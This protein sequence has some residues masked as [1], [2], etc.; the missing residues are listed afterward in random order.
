MA[1]HI[2]EPAGVAPSKKGALDHDNVPRPVA[3]DFMYD[4][5]YNHDLPTADVLGVEVPTDCDAQREAENIMA[6]LSKATSKED[7]V[8]FTDLFFDHGKTSSH[9]VYEN[10]SLPDMIGVWR[11]KLSFTWDFRT[12][13]FKEAI[14]KAATD[15]L[16]QTKARNFTLLEPAPKVARPYP[17]FSQLQFV[18]AFETQLVFASAVINAVLTIEG[19]KIYTM[20]T[21]AE[22]LKDFPEQGAPDGHMTGITSWESQRSEAINTADP[23]VLIVG[24]GQK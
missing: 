16:P 8:A 9:E 24:G 13:N 19:W 22:G 12:F 14:L 11:D 5:K 17:D 20:H 7:P 23:E 4:F 15:L 21:V 18:V 1:P 10:P 3:D 6:S 2:N